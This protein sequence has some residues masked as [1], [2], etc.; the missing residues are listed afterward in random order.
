MCSALLSRPSF[1]V[2]E[3]KMGSQERLA[4]AVNPC[5]EVQCNLEGQRTS[6]VV[7]VVEFVVTLLSTLAANVANHLDVAF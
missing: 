3:M 1:E 2:V 6:Q 4:G 7:T 5:S